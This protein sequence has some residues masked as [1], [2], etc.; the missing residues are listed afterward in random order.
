MCHSPAIQGSCLLYAGV[1]VGAESSAGLTR[2]QHFDHILLGSREKL[3]PELR[4]EHVILV[5]GSFVSK[6]LAQFLEWAA[7]SDSNG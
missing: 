4:P 5:G 1:K 3:W 7:T 2:L 6:R